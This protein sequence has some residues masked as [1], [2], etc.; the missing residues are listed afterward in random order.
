MTKRPSSPDER[1][2]VDT[3]GHAQHGLVD[4]EPGQ[5]IG[6]VGVG[7]RVADLDLGEAGQH[8]QVAGHELV[9]LGAAEALD[10][11]QLRRAGG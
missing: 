6:V 4:G 8:E 11:Q 2:R 1:R 5:R 7:Q 10:G 9:D 3:E